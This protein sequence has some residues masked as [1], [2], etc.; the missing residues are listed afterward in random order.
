MRTSIQGA[1]FVLYVAHQDDSTR[2]YQRVLS[3]E[4]SLYV[5]GMTEFQISETTKLGLMPEEGIVRLLGDAIP[6]PE[7]A[8]GIP[9]TET[10]LL[11][12]NPD[13]FHQR[14]LASG[15]TEL[16]PLSE[17]DWGDRAAYSLDPDGHVLVFAEKTQAL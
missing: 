8:A 12:D 4:P 11:V 1:L 15:A 3:M 6:N 10:Y 2:F 13:E 7:A 17:R 16:S 5:P 14:A 9:R